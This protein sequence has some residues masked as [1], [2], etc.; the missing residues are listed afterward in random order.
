MRMKFILMGIITLTFLENAFPQTTIKDINLKPNSSLLKITKDSKSR[1]ILHI[2]TAIS[3]L[4]IKKI[5]TKGGNF[6]TLESEGLVKI[7][8]KG[9]PNIPVFSKLIEAPL[10]AQ[11]EFEVLSYDEEIVD[12][13]DYG[14]YNK[15]VSAQP[16]LSKSDDPG[17]MPFYY[18][19]NIYNKNEYINNKSK[20]REKNNKYLPKM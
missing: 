11:V 8:G 5:N 12:L 15:I 3:V 14:I 19:D 1:D 13:K 7:F 20:R 18:D 10:N 16:S 17:A 9:F 6:I 4:H 2:N